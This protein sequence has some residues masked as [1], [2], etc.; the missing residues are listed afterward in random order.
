MLL[1]GEFL[2]Q[3]L[4]GA[5]GQ[6]FPISIPNPYLAGELRQTG[7]TAPR[8]LVLQGCVCNTKVNWLCWLPFLRRLNFGDAPTAM[9][10]LGELGLCC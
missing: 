4:G 10:G 9:A 1:V 7:R 8:A 6:Q 2:G 5:V 3:V